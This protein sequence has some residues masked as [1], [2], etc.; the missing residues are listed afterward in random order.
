MPLVVDNTKF[1]QYK[2]KSLAATVATKTMPASK[3]CNTRFKKRNT[4]R[5]TRYVH[6]DALGGYRGGVSL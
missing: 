2:R 4:S 3:M 1:K 6:Q 5:C